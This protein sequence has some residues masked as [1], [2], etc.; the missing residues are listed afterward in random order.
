MFKRNQQDSHPSWLVNLQLN[1]LIKIE[2]IKEIKNNKIFQLKVSFNN[3]EWRIERNKDDINY[4]FS[5]L[6]QRNQRFSRKKNKQD[7]NIQQQEQQGQQG[8]QE[9]QEEQRGQEAQISQEEKDIKRILP[10]LN[11]L[12]DFECCQQLENYFLYLLTLKE[13]W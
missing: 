9:E 12:N 5:T 2:N 8:E 11:E 13:T 7:N 1:L 6:N 3:F 10:N 4:L